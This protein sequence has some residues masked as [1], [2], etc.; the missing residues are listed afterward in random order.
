MAAQEL[1]LLNGVAAPLLA[2][3]AI[4]PLMVELTR[5]NLELWQIED[6]LRAHEQRQ[7]FDRDFVELARQ[8]Y[9]TNDE[10]ARIK[11]EVNTAAGCVLVE[12]KEHPEY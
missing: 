5:V 7:V 8:V 12:V 1:A 4:A 10:R 9:F 11:N 6:M 2:A 3:P